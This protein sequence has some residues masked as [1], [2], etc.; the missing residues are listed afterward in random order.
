MDKIKTV[1][2]VRTISEYSKT[3][4]FLQSKTPVYS[5]ALISL[6]EGINRLVLLSVMLQIGSKL[7]LLFDV[8]LCFSVVLVLA[9]YKREKMDLSI[10]RRK[11]ISCLHESVD[12]Y[13]GH[14]LSKNLSLTVLPPF[15]FSSFCTI[16]L[17]FLLV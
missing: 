13:F 15:S 12:G 14:Q 6:A 3:L 11:G 5:H 7:A 8:L 17:L 1:K 10:V 16:F 9:Q 2:S 4:F